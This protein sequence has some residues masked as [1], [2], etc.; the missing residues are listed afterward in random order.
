M[1]EDVLGLPVNKCYKAPEDY[2]PSHVLQYMDAFDQKLA[3]HR[4]TLKEQKKKVNAQKE[5]DPHTM[6]AEEDVESDEYDSL[7][8]VLDQQ[9]RLELGEFDMDC[10]EPPSAD[11]C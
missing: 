9:R 5:E 11:G 8:R 4:R 1:M 2:Q 7:K 6:E 10:A 3:E